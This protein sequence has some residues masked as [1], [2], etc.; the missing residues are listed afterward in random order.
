MTPSSK[1]I[2]RS[3]LSCVFPFHRT[4]LQEGDCFYVNPDPCDYEKHWEYYLLKIS[5]RAINLK[6]QYFSV[7]EELIRSFQ[8]VSPIAEN[9]NTSSVKF[10]TI[11]REASNL[12]EQVSRLIYKNLF[13]ID[14][15]ERMIIFHY[16]SLNKFLDFNSYEFYCPVLENVADES[17]LLLNPFKELEAWDRDSPLTNSHIPKWWTAYN[18]IK[19]SPDELFYFS[20]LENAVRALLAAHII[21]NRYLGSGV[22]SGDLTMSER[23]DNKV[24]HR[25]LPVKKSELFMNPEELLGFSF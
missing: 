5:K 25:Q 22:V 7:E 18:K 17:R 24:I 10:A 21:I 16:L 11:I 23:Q 3:Q 19:H 12:F 13:K 6:L 15:K 20:T 8:F 2:N 4:D 1:Q 14:K 9:L